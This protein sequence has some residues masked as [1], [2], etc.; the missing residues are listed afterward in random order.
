VVIDIHPDEIEQVCKIVED[1]NDE[2]N[3]HVKA[4]FDVD[5]NVPLLLEAKLGDNWLEQKDV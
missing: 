3:D 1:I 5:I 2:L 4:W